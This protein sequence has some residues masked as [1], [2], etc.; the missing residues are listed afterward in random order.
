MKD[1]AARFGDVTEKEQFDDRYASTTV[2][3]AIAIEFLSRFCN[4]ESLEIL[5][6]EHYL[7]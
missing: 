6:S 1:L 5:E 2:N 4:L 7:V 3:L